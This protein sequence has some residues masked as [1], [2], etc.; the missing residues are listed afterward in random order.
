[1][2]GCCDMKEIGLPDEAE[3]RKPRRTIL[4]EKR[5]LLFVY[6]PVFVFAGFLLAILIQPKNGM[7][8]ATDL[9]F[10]I[11]LNIFAFAWCRSDARERGYALHRLFPYGV[12]IFG[13]LHL[14]IIF[15]A[16]EDSR[17]V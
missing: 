4:T 16:Q 5:W 6:L 13:T 15:F 9:V 10:G 2:L 14:S 3:D 11:G 1:M 17:V 12:V 8:Q 7:G